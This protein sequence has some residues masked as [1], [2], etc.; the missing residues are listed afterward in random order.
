[1]DDEK[2]TTEE[3]NV[4]DLS[5]EEKVDVM[6]EICWKSFYETL[7]SSLLLGKLG[8][9][10]YQLMHDMLYNFDNFVEIIADTESEKD[11]DKKMRNM[12]KIIDKMEKILK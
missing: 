9:E 1:M 3:K 11:I 8:S 6:N 2:Y 12:R 7:A 5:M 4:E 10:L